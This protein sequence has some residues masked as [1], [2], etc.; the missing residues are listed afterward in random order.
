MPVKKYF[1]FDEA[2]RDLWVLHPDAKYYRKLR[3]FYAFAFR[4]YKP[5]FPKG[6][7]KFRNMEEANSVLIP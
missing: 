5:H 2:R 4:F 6:V 7:F 1:S 3:E